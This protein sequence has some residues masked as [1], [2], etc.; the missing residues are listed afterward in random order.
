MARASATFHQIVDLNIQGA[1]LIGNDTRWKGMVTNADGDVLQRSI[2]YS[3]GD[4][5]AHNE[6]VWVATD[7]SDNE[8]PSDISPMW[9]RV[10][11]SSAEGF[12]DDRFDAAGRLV[13]S[14]LRDGAQASTLASPASDTDNLSDQLISMLF[15]GFPPGAPRAQ[16]VVISAKNDGSFVQGLDRL[17][18]ASTSSVGVISFSAT[19]DA[20]ITRAFSVYINGGSLDADSKE[21][22]FEVVA[23]TSR[24]TRRPIRIPFDLS[25]SYTFN[26]LEVPVGNTTQ[27]QFVNADAIT[28]Q[29]LIRLNTDLHIGE[30]EVGDLLATFPEAYGPVGP[31]TGAY[32][33]DGALPIIP[34]GPA[35]GAIA[36]LDMDTGRLMLSLTRDISTADAPAVGNI[37]GFPL[38]VNAAGDTIKVFGEIV[39][40]EDGVRL[41]GD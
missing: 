15:I 11:R 7:P 35:S 17:V 30:S 1:T 18:D 13:E 25:P 36:A 5:V 28:F 26:T 24:S 21:F 31:I 10:S 4:T 23:V 40:N 19:D 14:Y 16:Q 20:D 37:I 3:R 32:P 34:Y 39:A 27:S 41:S 12:V 38:I 8:E 2:A 9:Q 22:T 6:A 33:H 29:R